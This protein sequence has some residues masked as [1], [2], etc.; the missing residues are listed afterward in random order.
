MPN[1]TTIKNHQQALGIDR[2][3]PA[4]IAQN[5]VVMSVKCSGGTGF[6]SIR[7]ITVQRLAQRAF[8][9]PGYKEVG[10]H[11]AIGTRKTE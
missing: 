5:V 8:A 4:A 2:K 10:I 6:R 1:Q 3:P 11:I 9:F 7:R